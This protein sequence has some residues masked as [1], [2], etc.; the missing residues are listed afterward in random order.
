MGKYSYVFFTNAVEGRD[1]EYNAWYTGQH[2]PDVLQ[3]PGFVAATRY[4]LTEHGAMG[5][6]AQH[7][8][9]IIYEVETDTPE[10]VLAELGHRAPEMVMSDALRTDDLTGALWE[11]ITDRL[12]A[13]R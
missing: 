7:R 1:D 11:A 12:V 10:A 6:T 3:V 8:Y 13:K 4:R 9:L 2:V 5:P